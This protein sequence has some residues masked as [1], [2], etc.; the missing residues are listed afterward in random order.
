MRT[1]EYEAIVNL[2]RIGQD[3]Y[4]NNRVLVVDDEPS[5]HDDFSEMLGTEPRR[6]SDDFASSVFSGETSSPSTFT[7]AHAHSGNEAVNLVRKSL[8]TNEHF[9]IAF[10]DI[11]MPPGMDGVETIREIRKLDPQI[12]LVVMTAHTDKTLPEIVEGV[13]PI[14]K[15]LYLRKPFNRDEIHQL[16]VALTDKYAVERDLIEHEVELRIGKQRLEAILSSTGDA[17]VF[18]NAE[19]EVAFANRN[20]KAL[21][22]IGDDTLIGQSRSEVALNLSSIELKDVPYAYS[23][24]GGDAQLFRHETDAKVRLFRLFEHFVASPEDGEVIGRL[25]I[26]RDISLDLRSRQM[27]TEVKQLRSTLESSG[28]GTGII[29]TSE[30]MRHILHLVE[31]AVHSDMPVLI[32]GESGTGKE[33]VAN[34]LHFTGPRKDG[35][36]V[37]VNC[38]ALPEYLVES[39]LFGHERGAFTG[40]QKLRLGAFEQA[41]GGTLFLDEIGDMP[42]P[43]QAKLLRVLQE[44][45]VQ[46]LG[47]SKSIP[48]D[49]Q[50]VCATNNDLQSTIKTGKFRSDLYYRIAGFPITIPP[51]RERVEDIQVLATHFLQKHS[52]RTGRQIDGI[53]EDAFQTM[54][55]YDWPGNVRELENAIGRAVL[56][57]PTQ[58]ITAASLWPGDTDR[59]VHDEPQPDSVVVDNVVRLNDV[60]RAAIKRAMKV[61]NNNVTQA[62]RSLGIDRTTLHRKL[63]RFDL[64]L[65]LA[66]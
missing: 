13:K 34:A 5:I 56:L 19:D 29:G 16:A 33:L 24:I 4:R 62:A 46:R 17:L 48:V 47:D 52:E 41:N 51:L 36:F 27:E 22:E 61:A 42:T 40:A 8:Q 2:D 6:A 49:V 37:A 32:Q 63:K 18:Y 3:G 12:E 25:H 54:L 23:V 38:A 50:V 58:M 45:V 65:E 64:D 39:E 30:Q 14:H 28:S 10:V 60:E 43:L 9:A 1:Q 66:E 21:C 15:L 20:F 44:R 26:Y 31:R 55:R 35:P 53:E 11:R 57:E 59:H 7:M